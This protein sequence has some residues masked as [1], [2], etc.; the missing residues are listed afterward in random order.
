MLGTTVS[1]TLLLVV[2]CAAPLDRPLSAGTGTMFLI[3]I[4]LDGG[5]VASQARAVGRRHHGPADL[6]ADRGRAGL[7]R[8]EDP[9]GDRAVITLNG[10]FLPYRTW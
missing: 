10:K 9:K 6:P 8:V 2:Y 5:L 4:V 3:G 1:V 7:Q